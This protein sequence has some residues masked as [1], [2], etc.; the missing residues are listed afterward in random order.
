MRWLWFSDGDVLLPMIRC[1]YKFTLI[2]RYY[3]V[4]TKVIPL[5]DYEA[6]I[7]R[8]LSRRHLSFFLLRT[9]AFFP[10]K[11]HKRYGDAS[12]RHVAVIYS[13]LS[14]THSQLIGY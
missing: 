1:S 8:P 10:I 5:N 4:A 9:Y 6:E 7:L 12:D 11:F 13:E 3:S 2:N 14:A